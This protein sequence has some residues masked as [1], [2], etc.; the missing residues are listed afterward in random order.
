MERDKEQPYIGK[1][2]YDEKDSDG[3]KGEGCEYKKNATGDG[4]KVNAASEATDPGSLE[5][6][7]ENEEL[8]RLFGPGAPR[9]NNSAGK[10]AWR[11][12]TGGDPAATVRA[13][14]VGGL[15]IG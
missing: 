8:L 9:Q 2:E 10:R 5:A 6:T 12:G 4:R 14:P 7:V 11:Q 15:G 1:P 3:A 13:M